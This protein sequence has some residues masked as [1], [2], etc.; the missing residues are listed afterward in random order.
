MSPRTRCSLITFSFE[1]QLMNTNYPV[2]RAISDAILALVRLGSYPGNREISDRPT[3][4]PV[5]SNFALRIY[6]DGIHRSLHT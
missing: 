2:D 6:L 1:R 4:E 3:Y 5:Y